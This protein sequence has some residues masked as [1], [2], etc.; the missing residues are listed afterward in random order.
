MDA[1]HEVHV[2]NWSRQYPQL[3]FPGKTQWVPTVN[4]DGPD[5][6]ALLDSINPLT[7]KTTAKHL[8]DLGPL[9]AIVFPFWHAML[10]PALT[11][12]AKRIRRN[13]PL[14]PQ[15]IGLFHNAGSHDGPLIMERLTRGLLAQMDEVWT[16]S[17]EVK[18]EL[19]LQDEGL[20]TRVLFHPLYNH[21]PKLPDK[22][23]AREKMGLPPDARVFLFFGLIRPYKG[24]MRLLNV[25]DDFAVNQP[26]AH[27]L[28]AGECYG[29]WNPYQ[30]AIES[31]DY[32]DRIL[33]DP[34]FIPD[35]EVG[36]TFGAADVVVLPYESASQSG[37][38]AMSL[39]Y[40][41]PT[42]AS[43]VGGLAE[44]IR[45]GQTGELFQAGN[46]VSLLAALQRS[47]KIEYPE[48]AF[49]AAREQ[50]SWTRFAATSFPT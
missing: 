30:L 42:I 25:W 24:L 21:F 43:D 23:H 33:V 32:K 3:L 14:P 34:R 13:H 17:H 4:S 18:D 16:L 41:I 28:I 36:T 46:S 27:L 47:M 7:W 38:T 39:H 9:D 40:G 37:V 22:A 50:F 35:D 20:N 45:P 49:D 10:A 31:L 12:V 44:Y 19:L 15:L 2:V 48:A 5:C 26:N 11:G 8:K 6:P 29:D 1:G